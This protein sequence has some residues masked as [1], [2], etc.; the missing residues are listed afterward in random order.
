MASPITPQLE[1]WHR[2][3][4]RRDFQ[5]AHCAETC[6]FTALTGFFSTASYAARARRAQGDRLHYDALAKERRWHWWRIAC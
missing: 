6:H 1:Y 3:S 4:S 5:E 2:R